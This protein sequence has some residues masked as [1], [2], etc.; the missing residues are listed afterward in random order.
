MEMELKGTAGKISDV[1]TTSHGLV[2]EIQGLREMIGTLAERRMREM[3]KLMTDNVQQGSEAQQ[4]MLANV[5]ASRY[6]SAALRVLSAISAGALGMKISDIIIRAAAPDEFF[7]SW[8]HLTV[9]F[10]LWMILTWTFFALIKT[11][12]ERIKEQKLAER[13][14]LNVRFPLD[15]RSNTSRI[16]K[17]IDSKDV[18]LYNVERTTHRVAWHHS[19]RKGE[20]EIFYVLTLCFDPVNGHLHY[21]HANTEDRRGTVELTTDLVIRELTRGGLIDMK[22]ARDIDKNMGI[23]IEGGEGK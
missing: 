17:F 15:V 23:Q 16:K 22:E 10:I 19:E 9:G 7:G 21:L 3:S 13:Y 11:G 2:D 6:S 5:R 1:E 14:N 4:I 18:V 8:V 12:I 20:L